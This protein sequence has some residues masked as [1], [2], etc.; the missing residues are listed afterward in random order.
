MGG[1]FSGP[2]SSLPPITPAGTEP[3]GAG[4][5][6]QARSSAWGINFGPSLPALGHEPEKEAVRWHL[7]VS[8]ENDL[9]LRTYSGSQGRKKGDLA[10]FIEGAVRRRVLQ[11]TI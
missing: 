8:K 9:D 1:K 4:G 10:T 6:P 3:I 7:K 5:T 11:F 2:A